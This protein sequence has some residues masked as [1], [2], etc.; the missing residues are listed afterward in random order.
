MYSLAAVR[1][2]ARARAQPFRHL[3]GIEPDQGHN[4]HVAEQQGRQRIARFDA[5]QNPRAIQQHKHEHRHKQVA[6]SG[7]GQRLPVRLDAT[8]LQEGDEAIQ[9]AG[10]LQAVDRIDPLPALQG[11]GDGLIIPFRELPVQQFADISCTSA[12]VWRGW[13]DGCL[14]LVLGEALFRH[15]SHVLPNFGH[16]PRPA[17]DCAAHDRWQHSTIPK[18]QHN[19]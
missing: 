9:Q 18:L 14:L 1:C 12:T 7:D 3:V 5:E 19:K 8:G 17:T 2:L 13:L 11:V 16:H 6:Y 15:K 4:R 10:V